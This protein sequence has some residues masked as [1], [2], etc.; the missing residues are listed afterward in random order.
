MIDFLPSSWLVNRHRCENL[1]SCIK[2]IKPP[3][4]SSSRNITEH[5][6]RSD[7]TPITHVYRNRHQYE[8][9]LFHFLWDE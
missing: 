2:I 7:V 5:V 4:L 6:G 9:I 1:K 8:D 3:V